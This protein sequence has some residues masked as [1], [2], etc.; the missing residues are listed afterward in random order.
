MNALISIIVPIYNTEAYL[1]KCIDSIRNQTYENIEIILVDDGSTDSSPQI[2]DRYAQLDS[3]IVVLHRANAGV[4]ASRNAG[5]AIA[6]G[7]YI[8][9]V[10]SDDWIEPD[11]YEKMY[12]ACEQH[13]VPLAMCRYARVRETQVKRGGTGQIKKYTREELLKYYISGAED[14]VVNNSVWSKLFLKE[15]IDDLSFAEG[16][17]SEDIMYTTKLLCKLEAGVYLDSCLYNYKADREGSIMNSNKVQRVIED[18]VP[19]WKEHISYIRESVSDELGDYAEF[20]FY[21]RMLSYY[22]ELIKEAET[23]KLAEWIKK[24]VYS[25]KRRVREICDAQYVGIGDKVRMQL[26]LLHPVLSKGVN[27]LYVRVAKFIK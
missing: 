10:D 23:K 25:D 5:L 16:R 7:K 1:E 2:C 12:L 20:Y 22:M 13:K 6:N 27:D 8:G 15:L 17:V 21:K 3:R 26:F 24:V 4:S 19:F 18:E 11:M 9:C 14:V